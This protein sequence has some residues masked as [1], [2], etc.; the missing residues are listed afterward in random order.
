[1]SIFASSPPSL[2][3]AHVSPPYRS[4]S[5]AACDAIR[6]HRSHSQG[7]AGGACGDMAA[8]RT[9]MTRA[10]V[11]VQLVAVGTRAR[12]YARRATNAHNA[13]THAINTH[14]TVQHGRS[15]SSK[16]KRTR[17]RTHPRARSTLPI[18]Q[19]TQCARS[20]C[21]RARRS[22]GPHTPSAPRRHGIRSTHLRDRSPRG[23][24]PSCR[25]QPPLPD[26]YRQ[27]IRRRPR[28]RA[29]A[30]RPLRSLHTSGTVYTTIHLTRRC[31]AHMKTRSPAR[32]LTR[33]RRASFP[34]R[35]SRQPTFHHVLT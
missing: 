11:S 32:A 9:H 20:A 29:C 26:W 21:T 7:P 31:V 27:Q 19:R 6:A 23:A 10:R 2:H 8:Q 1:M 3:V 16:I 24:T 17:V 18:A 34:S 13:H 22:E 33:H 5:A 14:A 4:S 12:A 15:V 35:G 28:A 30:C 25:G